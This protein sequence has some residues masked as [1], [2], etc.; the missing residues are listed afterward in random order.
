MNDSISSFGE[1]AQELSK[2]PL[3]ILGLFILLVYAVAATAAGFSPQLPAEGRMIL[4]YFIVFFPLIV[5]FVFSWLLTKHFYKIIYR[6]GLIDE[7]NYVTMISSLTAASIKQIDSTF[8]GTDEDIKRLTQIV[9]ESKQ[10]RKSYA[11]NDFKEILWVDDYPSNNVHER[12]AFEAMGISFSLALS[13]QEAKQL[14][15][16]IKFD[17]IISDMGRKEG[18][19]EGYILL[20][21][22]RNRGDLTPF[23]IYS[24]SGSDEHRKIARERG[25]QGA[26]NNAQELFQM[27]VRT[28]LRKH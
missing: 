7:E 4:I 1:K 3:G 28:F 9:K 14:L 5:L 25:A 24:T 22:I 2:T 17:A 6:P 15:E 16:N 8:T 12:K 11:D 10:T 23:F 13:T 19:Q 26:T 20:D 27:V 18:P 21:E